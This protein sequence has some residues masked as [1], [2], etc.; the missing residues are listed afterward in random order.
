MRRCQTEPMNPNAR[1]FAGEGLGPWDREQGE[2][3]K[4]KVVDWKQFRTYLWEKEAG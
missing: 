1:E 2:A 4:E 3:K